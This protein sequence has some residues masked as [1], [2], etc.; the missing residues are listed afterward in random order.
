MLVIINFIFALIFFFI[1]L[2]ML[3]KVAR[4]LLILK[5]IVI[6]KVVFLLGAAK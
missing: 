2:I 3:Q 6:Y 4:I 5:T 1:F